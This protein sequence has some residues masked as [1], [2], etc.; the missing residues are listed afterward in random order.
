ME[1]VQLIQAQQHAHRH[2]ADPSDTGGAM[3]Q[4]KPP[5]QPLTVFLIKTGTTEYEDALDE[6]EVGRLTRHELE[7]RLPF[8]GALYLAPQRT[9]PPRWLSFLESGAQGELAH[10]YNASTSAVLFIRSSRRLFAFTFG[11]GRSLLRPTRIER[12]FGLRV[13]L[14]SVDEDG[15]QSVDTKTVQELTV[16]TRRQASRASRL[17]EFD[18]DKEEDLLGSVAGVPR[19]PVFARKVTGA[20]ALQFRASLEFAELGEKCRAILRAYRS[21]DYKARGFEFVDHVRKV[22]DPQLIQA[23]DDE[24]VQTLASGQFDDMHMAPPEIIDWESVDGFSFVKSADPEPDLTL[25]AFFGQIR[26]PEEMSIARLKRQRVYVHVAGAAEP[27][28]R[29]SVYRAVVAERKTQDRTYVL[30]GGDWHEIEKGFAERIDR[31]VAKIASAGLRLPPAKQNEKEGAYNARVVRIGIYHLDQKCPRVEGD[32]V[33]LCDLYV[34]RDRQ[35]VHVKRWNRSSTLSHL[36]A[37]GLTSAEAL[38]SDEGFRMEARKLLG[39]Q[40]T[41]LARQIP[42][43]RPNPTNYRVVFAIIKG[44]QGWRRSLPFFSKLR[45]ARSAEALRRLGFD[46]RLERINVE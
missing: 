25:E 39:D 35:F 38:L 29:W 10:L 44:G 26:K 22:A 36:F 46:V 9:A 7:P 34:S 12:A 41:S 45:L 14:N 4:K 21:E 16:H 1:G 32:Q 33:E 18:V 42:A 13:V 17:A 23:L 37:Q 2:V 27:V 31:R 24:L 40:S 3:D 11:Y 30:S 19:D 20:D 6:D 8:Q 28:P 43:G 5:I 15:L